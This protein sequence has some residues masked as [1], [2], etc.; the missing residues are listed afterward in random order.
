MEEKKKNRIIYTKENYETKK[1]VEKIEIDS[2]TGDIIATASSPEKV[3]YNKTDSNL[4]EKA[5]DNEEFVFTKAHYQNDDG[6]W[7]ADDYAYKYRLEITGRLNNA[8]KNT[9]YV[10]LSNRKDITFDET[11]KS[12]LSSNTKDYFDPEDTVIV[13]HKLFD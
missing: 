3:K 8:A 6:L 10:V 1:V 11:W 5:Y 9:T 2:L 4:I 13:G 7:V 12:E